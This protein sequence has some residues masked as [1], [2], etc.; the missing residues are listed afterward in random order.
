MTE[1]KKEDIK[2]DD[3]LTMLAELDLK[4]EQAVLD[5]AQ[6]NRH[7]LIEL[8]KTFAHNGDTKTINVI[9]GLLKD[10]DSSV[11]TNRRIQVE[12]KDA[13]TNAELAR[14]AAL[15]LDN[16]GVGVRRHDG[17]QSDY[18]PSFDVSA[19]PEMSIDPTVVSSSDGVVDIDAIV[20]EGL[21]K[22]RGDSSDED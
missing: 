22:T 20:A 16:A 17:E 9:R 5:Y 4:D 15:L 2:K 13:D 12:S 11:Y 10:M 8:L 7:E 3:V 19:M 14:Q 6:R 21:R 1:E 18:A